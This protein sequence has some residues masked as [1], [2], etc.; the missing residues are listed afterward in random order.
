MYSFRSASRS[1][2]SSGVLAF[3]SSWSMYLGFEEENIFSGGYAAGPDHSDTL[4]EV[5]QYLKGIAEAAKGEDD[6]DSSE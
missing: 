4:S 2:S 5:I 6:P 3:A 1:A